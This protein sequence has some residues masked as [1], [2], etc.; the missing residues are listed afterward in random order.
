MQR[1]IHLVRNASSTAAVNGH[2]G[3]LNLQCT[4]FRLPSGV[5]LVGYYYDAPRHVV[6]EGFGLLPGNANF[7]GQNPCA[8]SLRVAIAKGPHLR[9]NMTIQRMSNKLDFDNEPV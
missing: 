6:D 1:A 7:T 4:Q 5:R 3:H 2:G 8:I 9:Q